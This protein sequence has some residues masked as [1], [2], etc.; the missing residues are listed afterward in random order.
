MPA[1]QA[2]TVMRSF[3][4][5]P[6]NTPQTSAF[7]DVRACWRIL[8]ATSASITTTGCV[9]TLTFTLAG[10]GIS[11]PLPSRFVRAPVSRHRQSGRQFL[12]RGSVLLQR[13]RAEDRAG[14]ECDHQMIHARNIHVR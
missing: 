4:V 14:P 1:M 9:E 6:I 8:R 13:Q 12:V 5:L 2:S 10:L 11:V 3:S 7:I